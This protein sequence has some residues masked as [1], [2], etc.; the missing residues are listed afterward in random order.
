MRCRLI[1]RVLPL[2]T[3]LATAHGPINERTVWAL[4]IQDDGGRTGLGEAAPL[5]GFGSETPEACREAFS[6]ALKAMTAEF[7]LGWLDRGRPE[8][9]LGQLEK[10]VAGAPCARQAI[11]GA[12]LDLLAQQQEKPLAAL[13]AAGLGNAS[14]AG[15]LAVNALLGGGLAEVS[16]AASQ[17]V[18]AGFTCFK[19]KVGGEGAL[20]QDIER[21]Y[22]VRAA[23]GTQGQLRVDANASW[24]LDQALEFAIEAGDAGL[25]FCEQPLAVDDLEGLSTLRRRTG[26]KV[27]VDEGVRSA[28]DIGKV[29]AAQAAD[30]VVLKPMFLGGWRPTMQAVQLARSCG[31]GV[32]VT[33]ALDGAIGRA[34]ATH[35]AAALGL[36]ER[37]HGLATGILLAEDITS[38]PLTVESGFIHLPDSAGLGIGGLRG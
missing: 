9:P 32:V 6:K 3:P 14:H 24:T 33:T 18:K 15:K 5:P 2:A 38:M 16:E 22:A 7:L 20:G 19:L 17:L 37:A 29:A 35:Y 27:A 4:S 28:V 26:L 30:V 36:A 1:K 31:L 11:E 21:V 10:L 34:H 25:E 12:L 13:L 23:I 8:A